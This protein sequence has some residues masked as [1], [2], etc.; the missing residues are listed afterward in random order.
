MLLARGPRPSGSG[1]T[2][3]LSLADPLD[4]AQL[5]IAEYIAYPKPNAPRREP[6]IVPPRLAGAGDGQHHPSRSQVRVPYNFCV[7][8]LALPADAFYMPA[9]RWLL[10]AAGCA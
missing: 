4:F 10:D 6:N 9:L 7:A 3:R 1:L 5:L 2:G 8:P